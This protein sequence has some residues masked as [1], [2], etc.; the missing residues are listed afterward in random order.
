ME[1]KLK[2]GKRAN[3]WQRK[4]GGSDGRQDITYFE[5]VRDYAPK[6]SNLTNHN[7][8]KIN[9]SRARESACLI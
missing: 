6:I 9:V 7:Q 3:E 1:E 8:K 5:E 2:R 4:V